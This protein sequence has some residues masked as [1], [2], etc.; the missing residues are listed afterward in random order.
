MSETTTITE[1]QL[2][3]GDY[4]ALSN[5]MEFDH[6]IEVLPGWRVTSR[7][8]LHAPSLY[9]DDLDTPGWT[10]MDGYSGQYGYSGPLMH[11]SEFI[12]GGMARDILD[13]P[14]VYVALVSYPSDDSEPTEWAVAVRD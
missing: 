8:D 5:V 4:L 1:E 7:H 13:T 9:D 11:Q 6:V 14:G 12:G 3:G 2:R 10:L